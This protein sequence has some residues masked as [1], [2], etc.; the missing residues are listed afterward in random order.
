MPD[1]DSGSKP[2]AFGDFSY[3]WII[4]RRPI[5]VRTLSESSQHSISL[6]IWPMS[7][8]DGKLV[9]PETIKVI[10]MNTETNG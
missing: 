1:T 5:G 2:I 6:G 9:R 7:S 3:Y 8:F 10:Q 4:G